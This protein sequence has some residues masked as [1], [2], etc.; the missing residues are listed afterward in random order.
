MVALV[1]SP[2]VR[3]GP[4]CRRSAHIRLRRT[5]VCVRRSLLIGR[6]GRFR[7]EAVVVAVGGWREVAR[8]AIVLIAQRDSRFPCCAVLV[9]GSML[10][11]A[12]SVGSCE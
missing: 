3:A 2:T 9:G 1:S 12:E 11:M 5:C 4:R 8:S 10:L 6:G 7:R